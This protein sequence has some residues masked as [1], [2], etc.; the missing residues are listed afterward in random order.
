MQPDYKRDGILNYVVSEL[1][2]R[3]MKPDN[4]WSYHYLHRAYG[5]FAAAGAEFYRRVVSVYED[6]AI[7][8]NGD[9]DAYQNG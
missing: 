4:G 5:V 2:G 9:I 3:T 7:A 1:V 8:N 6:K